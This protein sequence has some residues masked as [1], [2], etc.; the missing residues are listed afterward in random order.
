M[1]K[2]SQLLDSAEQLRATSDSPQVD[3][4]MLLCHVLEVDR[5]WLRTWPDAVVDAEQVE[6]FKTLLEAR[7]E[8]VPIAYLIGSRGFW[9]LDLKLTA[10]TLIPRP[11]TEL[12]VETALDLPLSNCS[13]VLDLGTGSGAIALALASE[14]P[15]WQLIAVDS[16]SDTLAVARQNCHQYKLHNVQMV[17]SDW[18]TDIADQFNLIV[19]NPPYI[20]R[21]DAHLQRGDVRFEPIAALVS[22]DDGLDD[23]KHIIKHS[24]DYLT[25]SGWLVVEHGFNQALA[26]RDLFT[27]AGFTEVVTRC[28]YSQLERV[29]LGQWRL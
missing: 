28:D 24:P 27:S 3:C 1:A 10:D 13:H 17:Q 20:E 21:N 25:D 11:E 6:Q 8:G 4:E 26:V 23:L 7:V 22:G 14:R 15:S 18:F 12:V 2:V 19:S 9:N 16:Q 5:S 29:T